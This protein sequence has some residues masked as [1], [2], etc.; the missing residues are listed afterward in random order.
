M[1][2][3]KSNPFMTASPLAHLFDEVLHRG[4]NNGSIKNEWSSTMP[5]VNITEN[6]NAFLLDVAAPGLEKEDFKITLDNGQL[7]IS[8]SKEKSTEN[9]EE[10]K[11]FRKE[12][13]YTSFKR[14][15]QLQEAIDSE[16]IKA[17]YVN[18]ILHLTLP[19]KEE[20]KAK[21]PR[22]ISIS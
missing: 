20:A 11:W 4:F 22:T 21:S 19:K 1:K 18:G 3:S 8:V 6:E 13:N 2:V 10:G 7:E 12:F 5:S 16:N 17:E 9:S 14:S 15:F